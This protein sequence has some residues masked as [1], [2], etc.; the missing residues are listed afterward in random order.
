MQKILRGHDKLFGIFF[1][2]RKDSSPLGVSSLK[3]V[4]DVRTGLKLVPLLCFRMAEPLFTVP[5]FYGQIFELF[6][7]LPLAE[8]QACFPV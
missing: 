7:L 3:T 1:E 2:V 8:V 6:A 5:L 4:I